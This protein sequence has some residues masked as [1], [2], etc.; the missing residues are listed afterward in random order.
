[1]NKFFLPTLAIVAFVAPASQAQTFSGFERSFDVNGTLQT[2][3]GRR[4]IRNIAVD[5]DNDGTATI[6]FS[7]RGNGYWNNIG[8]DLTF[9][10]RW[11][12]SNIRDSREVTVELDKV[13]GRTVSGIATLRFDSPYGNDNYNY[14]IPRTGDG[15]P[16]NGNGN[17]WY[18]NGNGNNGGWGNNNDNNRPNE[19]RRL[20]LEQIS[21]SAQLDG[22]RWAPQKYSG[23]FDIDDQQGDGP[24]GPNRGN[25]NDLFS[26]KQG[27]GVVRIN[28]ERKEN[29]RSAKVELSKGG[30]AKI[31]LEGTQTWLFEGS[32]RQTSNNRIALKLDTSTT[33]QT[34]RRAPGEGNDDGLG[35]GEIVLNGLSF[36]SLTLSGRRGN[37]G[38]D[39]SFSTRDGQGPNNGNGNNGNDSFADRSTGTGSYK[40]E[41]GKLKLDSLDIRLQR[42]QNARII[43]TGEGKPITLEGRWRRNGNGDYVANLSGTGDRTDISG[44]ATIKV[45]RGELINFSLIGRSRSGPCTMNFNANR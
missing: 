6:T 3:E 17:P 21:I 36:E 28:D 14:N 39:I 45:E 33:A 42:N 27:Y 29:L 22:N 34:T 18:G 35:N 8:S 30:D 15:K 12:R 7:S 2:P 37:Q 1:M 43:L 10:G 19:R 20:R 4:D 5:L 25:I 40:T 24:N 13:S 32:W 38:F 9:T 44:E 16:A 11:T 31:T 23:S 26:T 41:R